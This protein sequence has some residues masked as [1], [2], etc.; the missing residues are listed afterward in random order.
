MK[1]A[2]LF[3]R[4]GPYHVARIQAAS[5]FMSV[6]S[7]E[8]FSESAEYK[9][10]N[11]KE[12]C[13]RITLFEG[14]S[15]KVVSAKALQFSLQS[16][17]HKHKPDVV[18]VN[19]WS[20]KSALAALYW[21]LSNNVPAIVM[22]ESSAI[23][24]IR[25]SWKEYI[26]S[27]ILKLYASGL[28]GGRRHIDYLKKLGMA[29]ESIFTGYDVIDN[30]YFHIAA[31]KLRKHSTLR[32]RLKL[33]KRYFLA[34]SRFIQKKNLFQLINAFAV[35]RSNTAALPYDL[36]IL[37]DGQ[38]KNELQALINNLNLQL[39]VHLPGFKQYHELPLYYAFAN[40]FIHASTSEQWGLVVN[41]AMAA[42]LPVLVSERCGCAPEL[43]KDGL[44]GFTFDPFDKDALIS[45]M[46]K[47][48][49]GSFDL[50]L[51]GQKSFE[52]ISQWQP[53]QF[54]KGLQ[55]AAASAMAEP[56]KKMS[57]S[58][59]LVLKYLIFR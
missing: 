42:R 43:V 46:L 35:Y 2:I 57:I 50:E 28:V 7:I 8:L 9:W 56:C 59:K 23:D 33:P 19:G 40:V 44:N 22:S 11:I 30:S 13:N 54:G 4:F 3:D 47:I 27:R 45:R 6:I 36:V 10:D 38:L 41:E 31:K 51:M 21:C 32:Q 18:A 34:S 1:V 24:F 53:D 37:G 26:K 29:A 48:T 5:K 12:A 16:V 20:E 25:V 58:D 55:S 14:K 52:I 39:S 49:S 15:N 17:L